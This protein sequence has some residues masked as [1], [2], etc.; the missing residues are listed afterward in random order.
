MRPHRGRELIAGLRILLPAAGLMAATGGYTW[1]W[2]T[3]AE[4]VEGRIPQV[5]ASVAAAGI[6]VA[7]GTV[8]I[9]GFPYRVEIVLTGASA[10]A[11]NWRWESSE[12]RIYAQPW[13]LR[14]L[15]VVAGTAHE[16]GR[17]PG[18]TS[19]TTDVV[20][21]S[22]VHDRGGALRRISVEAAGLAAAHWSL[23][24]A[25]LHGRRTADGMEI[26]GR[27]TNGRFPGGRAEVPVM[28][29]ALIEGV[30]TPGPGLSALGSPGRPGPQRGSSR[31]FALRLRL[32]PGGRRPRGNRDP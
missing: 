3:V 2:H 26:A 12:F 8:S 1:W 27:L 7:P 32:G 18:S 13:N 4:R 5:V 10:A 29:Y 24:R 17:P 14:H 19:L 31:D 28:A 20:R 22:L 11:R 6:K 16:W 23:E 15:V 9:R 30:L 21:A 25:E